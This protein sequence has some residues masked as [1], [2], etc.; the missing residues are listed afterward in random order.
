MLPRYTAPTPLEYFAS[1]VHSDAEFALLEAAA[2][3]AQDEYP[4]LDV[5]QLLYDMDSL[6]ARLQRRIAADAPSLQRL[7]VLNQFFFGDL[8][9]AGNINHYDDPENSYL[10]TVLH[11]RRGI[12]VTLG[13]LWMELAQGVGLQARG[14]A[15]P[16]HFMVKALL[17]K[18]QVVMDP[19]TGQ[20]LSREDLSE[21][22]A[23]YQ[24]SSGLSDGDVS[25][26][27]YLQA[28][29]PREIIARVLRNLK[30]LYQAQQDWPRLIA[31]QNRLVVLLPL[32]WSEWRDRGLAHAESGHAD[33]AIPDLEMYLAHAPTS[34]DAHAV[35]AR[36]Q[37]LRRTRGSL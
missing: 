28:A 29:K 5:Q 12:P 1:L 24:R 31:V 6:Q 17:P 23:P 19:F 9:F 3:I 8:G 16:G 21:R 14:V 4:E 35:R 32:A 27:L 11:T 2:S 22:L 26:G 34:Q 7:Q 36:L 13:L 25:L 18:G 37:A 10:H 20:S 33:Q 30:E 15:F